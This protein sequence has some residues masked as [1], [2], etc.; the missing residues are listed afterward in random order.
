[1]YAIRS[2]YDFLLL[3]LAMTVVALIR[4]VGIILVLALL[5]APAAISGLFLKSF[6]ERII[7][8]IIF[9][10]VFC[11][12]GLWISYTIDISSGASIVI[13]SVVSYFI[14]FGIKIL[15]SSRKKLEGRS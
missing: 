7:G 10:A 15:I 1:M 14:S 13:L 6:K 9:G 8:S 4:V 2:Y 5:T 12:L 3:L 11:V